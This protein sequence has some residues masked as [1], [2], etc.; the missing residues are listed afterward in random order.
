M[1]Y[2]VNQRI[3]DYLAEKRWTVNQLSK[4]ID[5]SQPTVSRQI[6]GSVTLSAELLGGILRVFPELSAEWLLRGTGPVEGV[7]QD[8]ELRAVCID[9]AKEILRLKMK[10]AELEG[11]K[12]L[13]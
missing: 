1:D 9:Q 10:I 12:K 11:E 3:K 6:A 2:S 4:A 13:A 7:V 5:L 8:A